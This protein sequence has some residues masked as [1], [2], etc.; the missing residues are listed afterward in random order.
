[1]TLSQ[2]PV[3]PLSIIPQNLH[4]PRLFP[5]PPQGVFHGT[6]RQIALK[7][8]EKAVFPVPVLNGTTLYL[9]HIQMIVD[10]MRQHVVQGTALVGT[11]KQMLTFFASFLNIFWLVTMMNLV[12][13]VPE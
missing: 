11:S 6:I 2:L 7:I 9:G 4:I 1:M 12:E 5:Q 3:A 10:K 13:L 8:N